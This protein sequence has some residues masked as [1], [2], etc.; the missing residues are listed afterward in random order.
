MHF[1][2]NRAFMRSDDGRLRRLLVAGSG[3]C[4]NENVSGVE[5]YNRSVSSINA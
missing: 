3:V 2:V 5:N 4:D 1:A